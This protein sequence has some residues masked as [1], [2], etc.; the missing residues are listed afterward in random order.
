MS[1][2]GP[3]E[4]LNSV[5]HGLIVLAYNWE[6]S[7]YGTM[8]SLVGTAVVDNIALP[9]K[10]GKSRD[11]LVDEVCKLL[12]KE[13]GER[14]CVASK[15]ELARTEKQGLSVA[16]DSCVLLPIEEDLINKG[17][18]SR[19]LFCPV[20]NVIMESLYKLGID[21]ENRSWQIGTTANPCC[22]HV[23]GIMDEVAKATEIKT[24]QTG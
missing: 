7:G 20:A 19:R 1:D 18:R 2:K 17:M 4:F 23:I 6:G 22:R 9:E 11:E 21:S 12:E 10:S 8:G 3:V 15:V 24:G 13:L 14:L 5:I 16:V